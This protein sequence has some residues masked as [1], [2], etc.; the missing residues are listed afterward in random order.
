MRKVMRKT[1]SDVSSA[2]AG[3]ALAA[4]ALTVIAGCARVSTEYVQKSNRPAA[5]ARG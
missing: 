3:L 4:M 2:A 1:G 5:Q